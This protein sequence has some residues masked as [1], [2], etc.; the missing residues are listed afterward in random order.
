M[1]RYYKIN[2]TQYFE[3]ISD[4]EALNLYND[5]NARMLIT[6]SENGKRYC[7]LITP[8]IVEGEL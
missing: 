7:Y 6:L 3:I 1:N 5:K 2:L 4:E 8:T